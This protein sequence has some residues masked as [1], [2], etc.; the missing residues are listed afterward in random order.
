MANLPRIDDAAVVELADTQHSKC[1]GGNSVSVRL[2]PAAPLVRGAY[3]SKSYG[4]NS[5]RVRF[6]PRPKMNW[7]ARPAKAGWSHDRMGSA[8]TMHAKIKIDGFN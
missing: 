7:Q 1:C 2:R 3:D 4:G 5:M 8:P 6:S